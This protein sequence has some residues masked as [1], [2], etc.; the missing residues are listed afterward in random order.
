[1]SEQSD[2]DKVFLSAIVENAIEDAKMP[3]FV[4]QFDYETEQILS[5]IR[6]R[7]NAI[8]A[9]RKKGITPP[10]QKPLILSTAKY[11]AARRSYNRV[12]TAAIDWLENDPWCRN[13]LGLLDV[14]IEA[15]LERIAEIKLP[16]AA[17]FR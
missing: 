2:C 17:L 10:E 4:S 9:A 5:G 6:K 15:F 1:M 3:P 8:R 7:H 16:H 13:I 11:V 12:I 14:N